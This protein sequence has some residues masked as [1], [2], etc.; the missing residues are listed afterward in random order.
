MRLLAELFLMFSKLSAFSFGGG[1]VM[2]PIMM[3]EIEK[4]NWTD[5]SALTNVVAIAQM[6]PGPIAVNASVG[7]GY[8]IA[9]YGGVVAAFLG[10]AAPC[11]II[12]I[13]V[14]TFFFKIYNHPYVKAAL[15]GLRAVIT[16][17]I[18][19]AAVKIAL[20]SGIVAAASDK[21]IEKGLNLSLGGQ[22][23]FEIKSLLIVSA[24]FIILTKT[25]VHP[26]FVIAGAGLLGMLLF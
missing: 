21:F 22:H 15:Y 7:M 5:I 17:I 11:A 4:N 19:Y 16:G 6:S 3:S 10:V 23:L 9:G 2:I 24:S 25:K 14:A 1:Y 20:R 8:T 18:V 12:V 26:I 13:T